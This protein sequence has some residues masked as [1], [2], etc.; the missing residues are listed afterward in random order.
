MAANQ[1]RQMYA[2]MG[3]ANAADNNI[4]DTQGI[5]SVRELGYL[6]DEDVTNLCKTTRRP[7]GH[8]PNAA[9]VAGQL[10]AMA[11]TIPYTGIMISQRAET[12]MQL[13]SYT[14]RHHNRISRATNVAQMNPTSI[15]RL[16]ELKIKEDARVSD[17]P[18]APTID[19]KN[20]P[21][22]MDAIQDYFCCVLGETKAPL[23]YVIRD[24]AEVP[25][26]ADG[27]PGNY[28]TPENEMIACMPHQD[29]NGVDLPT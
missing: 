16:R 6:N 8:L 9:F 10:P 26:E 7:G 29:A 12:S 11:A 23:A 2:R 1:L 13:A 22:T 28:D 15:R 21:K 4:V 20:W 19:P 3:F 27:P 24:A 14:V 5:D 18:T 25:A 17:P